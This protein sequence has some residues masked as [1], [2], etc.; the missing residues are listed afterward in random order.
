MRR[1]FKGPACL[2]TLI[3]FALLAIL[4]AE[5]A[6]THYE[7]YKQ[8][9]YP[10]MR[11]RLKKLASDYPEVMRLDNSEELF[12]LKYAV[13]CEANKRCILDIVTI[14]DFHSDARNKV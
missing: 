2:L 5:A 4:H 11:T 7:A 9:L 3:L 14:S 13:D 10:E 6:E 1:I 8:V 12:D